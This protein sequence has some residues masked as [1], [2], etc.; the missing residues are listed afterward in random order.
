MEKILILGGTNFIGRNLVNHLIGLNH[1]DITLFNRGQRNKDLF[2]EIK[3]LYGDRNTSDINV[4]FQQE[5]DYVI[6]VSCYFPDSLFQIVSGINKSLKR[7]IFISTC[8]VYDN[9]A[10][11]S[12]LRDENAPMLSCSKEQSIDKSISS[13]GNRKAECERVLIKSGLNSSI[14]RPALVY[15]AYDN[16]DRLYYWLYQVKKEN[17]L[18]IPN[19]GK[20]LFSVTYV[21]DLIQA[22]IKSIDDNVG[23][24]V[25]NITTYPK[26]SILKLL[27][28]TSE[29][30]KLNLNSNFAD[31]NFLNKHQIE[32]W[33]GIPLW[34][35][36]DYFTFDNSKIIK[37]L[38]VELTDFKTSIIE[39]MNFY[40]DLG[41]K[42]PQYG[43]SEAVKNEL[44]D[45]L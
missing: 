5:W 2:P 19:K 37:N 27:E 25:Y 8:S 16:T 34:L 12:I 18:L 23:S 10:D 6:D 38:K 17:S 22:I 43:I 13:Y 35:D 9:Q 24:E 14:L 29:I 40:D 11:Q 20:D 30:S 4:I 26:L 3:K 32:Q 21:K 15:G 44:I 28:T 1:F 7:Y 36:C 39:T 45:L 42:E 31:V 33:T 41:W